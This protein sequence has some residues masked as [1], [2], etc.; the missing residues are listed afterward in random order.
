MS[1][2][3]S[4]RKTKIDL[5]YVS[6]SYAVRPNIGSTRNYRMIDDDETV[7]CSKI[8]LNELYTDVYD[9]SI[10]NYL[11]PAINFD[12]E[13]IVV[14]KLDK[15][16]YIPEGYDIYQDILS[17]II[18]PRMDKL[19]KKNNLMNMIYNPEIDNLP[20]K[21]HGKY[22]CKCAIPKAYPSGMIRTIKYIMAQ[23]F[24]IKCILDLLQILKMKEFKASGEMYN[25]FW[26]Y[27]RFGPIYHRRIANSAQEDCHR[28]F[29]FIE[30]IKKQKLRQKDKKMLFDLLGSLDKNLKEYIIEYL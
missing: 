30:N 29:L 18:H 20:W 10:L 1:I 25:L 15:N 16:T 19:Y 22:Y 8:D 27:E 3:D 26:N 5:Y 7:H 6:F 4:N 24:D 14:L 11:I 12:Y 23:S 2:L 17:I 21:I 28:H 9:E 13:L